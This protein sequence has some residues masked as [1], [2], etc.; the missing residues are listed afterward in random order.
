[1]K[2]FLA[3][4]N[5]RYKDEGG[6]KSDN[7]PLWDVNDRFDVQ[8]IKYDDNYLYTDEYADR[9]NMPINP[10][11]VS[12][13]P[14]GIQSDKPVNKLDVQVPDELDVIDSLDKEALVQDVKKK[15]MGG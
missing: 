4:F 12:G 9:W 3:F 15:L 6:Q 10:N 8:P 5:S 11:D 7:F 14:K 2:D 1:M 13:Q